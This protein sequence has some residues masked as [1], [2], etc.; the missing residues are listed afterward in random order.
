MI[1]KLL[2]L[3]NKCLEPYHTV[4]DDIQTLF[5]VGTEVTTSCA[6]DDGFC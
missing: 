5:S 4:F 2:F 3:D 1:I 6:D